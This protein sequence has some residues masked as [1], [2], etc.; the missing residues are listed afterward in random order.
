MTRHKTA[1]GERDSEILGEGEKDPCPFDDE[2]VLAHRIVALAA[3]DEPDDEAEPW[4]LDEDEI[5]RHLVDEFE[6]DPDEARAHYA[7]HPGFD[8]DHS[9]LLHDYSFALRLDGRLTIFTYV[10]EQHEAD[11]WETEHAGLLHEALAF[12]RAEI[13]AHAPERFAPG[14]G[15]DLKLTDLSMA[16]SARCYVELAL[17]REAEAKGGRALAVAIFGHDAPESIRSRFRPFV[18][19]RE[20]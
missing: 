20:G 19:A 9:R 2:V 1:H 7:A 13:V 17:R 4:R 6:F 15:L 18:A 11:S 8:A 14:G 3:L 10:G 12:A 16:R 5:L